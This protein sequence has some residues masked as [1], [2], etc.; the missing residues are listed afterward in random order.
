MKSLRALCICLHQYM[1][2]WHVSGAKNAE[3]KKLR[4]RLVLQF[5]ALR[6]DSVEGALLDGAVKGKIAD[7]GM[8]MRL[9]SEA[10]HASSVHCGTAFY[11]AP[12]IERER[13][14]HSESDVYAFGVMMWEIM[15]GCLVYYPWCACSHFVHSLNQRSCVLVMRPSGDRGHSCTLRNKPA[16]PRHWQPSAGAPSPLCLA[17]A[18]VDS[19]RCCCHAIA[20]SCAG[21]AFKWAAVM[22]FTAPQATSKAPAFCKHGATV[23]YDSRVI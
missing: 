1:H 5:D 22:A 11:M 20:C 6:Y 23:C 7:F 3:H 16:L 4:R 15:M 17:V 9:G 19:E 13:K 14:F 18:Y 10:S 12:E 8:A 21:H 2:V